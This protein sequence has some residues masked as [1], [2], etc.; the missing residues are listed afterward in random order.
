MDIKHW[1][2]CPNALCILFAC[3]T[4]SDYLFK[5]KVSGE[6]NSKN[7]SVLTLTDSNLDDSRTGV[8]RQILKTEPSAKM[9]DVEQEYFW[10]SSHSDPIKHGEVMLQITAENCDPWEQK[11]KV[12]E[13]LN[14]DYDVEI[15]FG[16]IKLNCK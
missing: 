5:F 9:F 14:E 6:V 12:N 11:Y 16:R 15:N 4:H 3:S 1:F 2:I 8:Q 10:G 7:P 13:F